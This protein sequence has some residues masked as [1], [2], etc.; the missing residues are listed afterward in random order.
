MMST[1]FSISCGRTAVLRLIQRVDRNAVFGSVSSVD[2]ETGRASPEFRAQAQ[3]GDELQVPVS[4]DEIDVLASLDRSMREWLVMGGRLAFH[5][6][7]RRICREEKSLSSGTN[8][9]SWAARCVRAHRL[10]GSRCPGTMAVFARR[11]DDD[12]SENAGRA[13]ATSMAASDPERKTFHPP[14]APPYP[15]I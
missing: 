4:D 1:S 3:T 8:P 15:G 6:K 5:G 7:A 2:L 14:I 9:A 13:A 12:Q 11:R 10:P